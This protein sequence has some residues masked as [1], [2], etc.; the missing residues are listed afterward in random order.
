[1][2]V[3]ASESPPSSLFSSSVPP[4]DSAWRRGAFAYSGSTIAIPGSATAEWLF[5]QE[6]ATL[7]D[8]GKGT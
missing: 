5:H 2:A 6:K 7:Q 3:N 1:M 4:F 8:A